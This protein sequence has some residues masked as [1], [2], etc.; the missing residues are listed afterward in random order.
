[1]DK[2]NNVNIMNEMMNILNE[3]KELEKHIEHQQEQIIN[4]TSMKNHSEEKLK[5]YL[6]LESERDK[7]LE[8]SN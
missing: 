3:I 5:K 2:L 1:M 7:I 8:L 6:L 4:Y